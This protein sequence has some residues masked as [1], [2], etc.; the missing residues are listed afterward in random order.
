MN[1]QNVDGQPSYTLRHRAIRGLFDYCLMLEQ[2]QT[3]ET[4][5]G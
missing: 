5:T 2:T 4:F 1:G 3:L